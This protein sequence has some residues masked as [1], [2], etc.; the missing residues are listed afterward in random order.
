VGTAAG[1]EVS[2]ADGA[3]RETPGALDA[4]AAMR[5]CAAV[6]VVVWGAAVVASN[7]LSIPSKN[8]QARGQ[9]YSGWCVARFCLMATM[10]KGR[11]V[12]EYG[13]MIQEATIDFV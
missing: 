12:S 6:A 2:V 1:V 8:L 7:G 9:C 5:F 11:V 3:V 4:A 13:I 10:R